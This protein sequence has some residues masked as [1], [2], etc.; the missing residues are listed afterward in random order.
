[1][2]LQVRN[3]HKFAEEDVYE[4]GCQIGT[5]SGLIVDVFFEATDQSN[6]IQQICDFLGIESKENIQ[7]NPCGD[8]PS[9]IDFQVYE[10]ADGFTADKN[11]FKEWKQGSKKLWLC[12]YS[13]YVES[14]NDFILSESF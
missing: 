14:V 4:D 1:M 6:L 9:R 7:I 10:T 3:L 5:S 13:A 8:N 11:D 12:D 2:K